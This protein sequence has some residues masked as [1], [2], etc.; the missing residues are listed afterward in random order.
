MGTNIQDIHE[1]Q[2]ILSAI[3]VLQLAC[4]L[5]CKTKNTLPFTNVENPQEDSTV[6]AFR[7]IVSSQPQTLN[8]F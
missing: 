1:V 8:E 2:D 3:G 5:L 7:Q 6:E 4:T